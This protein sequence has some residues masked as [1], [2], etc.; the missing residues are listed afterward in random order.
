MRFALHCRAVDDDIEGCTVMGLTQD[1][2]RE[3]FDYR[4]GHLY[5]RMSR[6]GGR[7]IKAGDRA[8]SLHC[9]GYVEIGINQTK[10]L[11]HRLV[12]IWHHGDIPEGFEIDHIDRDRSKSRVEN[13]RLVLPAVNNVNRTEKPGESGYAGVRPKGRKWMARFQEKYIGTYSTAE[14]AHAAYQSAK[15][16]YWKG[17]Q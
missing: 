6:R 8:G 11:L 16:N 7:G 4:D 5:W 14:E 1:L 2:L 17:L 10:Y 3:L 9:E 13:L 12:W 15:A